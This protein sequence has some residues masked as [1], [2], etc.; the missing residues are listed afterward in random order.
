MSD[1]QDIDYSSMD[2][3]S[4]L[5]TMSARSLLTSSF[6]FRSLFDQQ[7]I[8]LSGIPDG[9]NLRSCYYDCPVSSRYCIFEP[10]LY[11]AGIYQYVIE[12]SRNSSQSF[13][14]AMVSRSLAL[15]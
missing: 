11:A 2:I 1:R 3:M 12:F 14:I 7:A 8:I 9:G 5:L 10:L 13:I 15:V 4:P 6:G